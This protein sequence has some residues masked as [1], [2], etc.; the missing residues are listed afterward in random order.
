MSIDRTNRQSACEYL[1]K[2]LAMHTAEH[3]PYGD[4]HGH[5]ALWCEIVDPALRHMCRGVDRID[6]YRNCVLAYERKDIEAATRFFC[7]A[8]NKD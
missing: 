6:E 4:P 3:M 8:E 7:A 5:N 1:G 2:M